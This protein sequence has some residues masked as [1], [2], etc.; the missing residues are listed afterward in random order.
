[1]KSLCRFTDGQ[2]LN[3]VWIKTLLHRIVGLGLEKTAPGFL[4]HAPDASKA[5]NSE[6]AE[7]ETGERVVH[8]DTQAEAFMKVRY[9]IP[10]MPNLGQR[11]SRIRDMR[12]VR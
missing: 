4:P 1:L 3:V 2:I 10:S 12:E 7:R 11:D 9:H 8:M 6:S 5:D